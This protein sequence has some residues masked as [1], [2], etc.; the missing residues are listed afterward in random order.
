MPA[1]LARHWRPLALRG[2]DTKLSRLL[3]AARLRM[4]LSFR[5]ASAMSRQ[6]AAELGDEQY[7]A[8]AGSRA[9]EPTIKNSRTAGMFPQDLPWA[10]ELANVRFGYPRR[11]GLLYIPRLEIR[12][13]EHVAFVGENGAGK[14]TLAKLISRLYDVDSG[15]ISIA[16]HDVRIS[17]SKV[18]VSRCAM[19]RLTRC[20]SIRP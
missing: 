1:E 7:F 20:S 3:R 9:L 12:A 5:E 6:V 4:G 15:S 19:S 13:G 14:S 2:N 16:G 17:R 10:I 18:F 8:A 11:D